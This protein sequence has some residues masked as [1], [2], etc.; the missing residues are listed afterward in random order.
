[1][2]KNDMSILIG[3]DAGQG[4][5]S[6]GNGF[7]QSLTKAGLFPFGRQDYRSRIRGGHNFFE[8]RVSEEEIY[9]HTDGVDLLVALT[10]DS[11]EKHLDE[12]VPGGGVLYD[13]DFDLD[14]DRFDDRDVQPFPVP[15]TSIATDEGGAKVMANTAA[16][17]AMAG[18]TGFDTSYINEIIEENF[19]VK[20]DSVVENN[21]QVAKAGK[22]YVESKAYEFDYEL[23]SL[24]GV[25]DRMVIDGNQAFALGAVTG[26]CNFVSAYPMTPSTSILEWLTKHS[27]EL[28][29]VIKQPESE[30]AAINIALGASHVG[31]RSLVT[32]SG[33]GF[34][35]MVEALGLAGMTETPIVIAE[36]QRPGPSTGLPTRTEQ[37]DLS[38]IVFASQ[39]DSPR[40]VLA[41]ATIEEAF[42][43]GKRAFDL[44]ERYQLPVVVL[45]D[46]HLADSIR[47]I[48]PEEF[49]TTVDIDRGELLSEEELEELEGDYLRH[50]FTESG[51]SPRAVPGNKNAVYKTTGNEH[52]ERGDITEDPDT[53]SRMMD[54]RMKKVD[55]ALDK[56]FDGPVLYGPEEADLTFIGWGSTYGAIR[57]AVD[58]LNEDGKKANFYHF[59]EIWPLAAGE[60]KDLLESDQRTVVVENNFSGQL[61]SL[62][63][64]ETGARVP[65][66]VLKYDGRPFTPESIL[67]EVR[68]L[69][70]VE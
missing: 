36:V 63:T 2:N 18:L 34:S 4:I 11:V 15:F 68:D 26:G 52:D 29:I 6:T 49:D 51:V 47:A 67:A 70:E 27:A 54:K 25:P 30:L 12:I 21:I 28:D 44:A 69:E 50:E 5:Q 65:D 59:D 55:T 57:E 1:M 33:G 19:S 66:T 58:R 23:S 40:L 62:I 20:G 22:E 56:E 14:S 35:L 38:S 61:A 24:S 60:V 64:R 8:I 31:A 42:R 3:G 41:P 32:T 17:G 7:I 43:A 45:S 53:R 10:K 13:E 48:R 39:G 46:Q 16:I 37:G 9:T